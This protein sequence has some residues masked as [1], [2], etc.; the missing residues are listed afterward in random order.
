MSQDA[1]LICQFRPRFLHCSR[2]YG[3]IG[4]VANYALR[5]AIYHTVVFDVTSQ[6]AEVSGYFESRWTLHVLHIVR[7]VLCLVQ[8]TAMT[9]HLCCWPPCVPRSPSPTGTTLAI[10]YSLLVQAKG[11]ILALHYSAHKCIWKSGWAWLDAVYIEFLWSPLRL[12]K[13]FVAGA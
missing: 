8:V 11:F 10:R 6:V 1:D 7:I 5:I 3:T 2:Q 9:G 13:R 4:L 12:C